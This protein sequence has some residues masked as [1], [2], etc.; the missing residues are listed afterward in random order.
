[1]VLQPQRAALERDAR[2][3]DL[4]TRTRHR[5]LVVLRLL[6]NPG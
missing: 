3:L 4:S 5:V 6:R 1:M 2:L